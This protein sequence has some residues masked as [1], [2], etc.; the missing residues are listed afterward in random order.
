MM[1]RK[2]KVIVSDQHLGAGPPTGRNPLEDFYSDRAFAAFLDEIAA[3]SDHLGAEV[4]LIFN[5]DT[6]EMLQVPH[7]DKFDPRAVYP[8]E[9][10]HSSAEKDSVRKMD[11]IIQ[12]HPA[13]FSALRDFLQEGPPLRYATFVKGN[14]DL[15]LHWRGVQTWIRRAVAATGDRTPLLAFEERCIVRED[16]YVEHGNQYAELI[17]R[18]KDIEEPHHPRQ[19]GQL[20]YPPGSWFVMNVFNQVERERYWVDGVKPVT[21]LIWYALKYDFAFAVQALAALI[22]A[23][24][25]TL[26]DA[27]LAVE[28][29]TA[30]DLLLR[31]ED[32]Q[33]AQQLEARYRD[34]PAFRA[35]FNAIVAA[36]VSPPPGTAGTAAS[37]LVPTPDAEAMAQQMQARMRSALSNAARRRA[38]EERVPLVV[39]GHSHEPVQERLPGGGRYINC[40]TWTWQADFTGAGKETWRDLFEHPERFTGDRQLTYARIDYDMIGRPYGCLMKYQADLPDEDEDGSGPATSL[41]SRLL[42]WLRGLWS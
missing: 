1:S 19:P 5:G 13:F 2:L 38:A 23:L 11:L 31:L 22:R 30:E 41:W 14:H 40:G 33:Q 37:A 4:E 34:E 21:A 20:W 39:F 24:P 25:G 28:G 16:I 12:G 15:D 29:S 7:V 27:F 42:A 32:P 10:Y 26:E 9:S 17:D 36:V 6:F 8:P 3:E 35:D 18:V